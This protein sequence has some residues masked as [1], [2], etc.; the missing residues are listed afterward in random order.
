MI[1]ILLL[2][3]FK[4]VSTFMK[5]M[6]IV[7][8]TSLFLTR[9]EIMSSIQKLTSQLI[10]E[11]EYTLFCS[12]IMYYTNHLPTEFIGQLAEF[13]QL[14]NNYL[15]SED[16]PC[17][18]IRTKRN[19]CVECQMK[20]E[21]TTKFKSI[22]YYAS[23]KPEICLQVSYKCKNCKLFYFHSYYQSE[24]KRTFEEDC[25]ENE[26]IQFTDE[27]VFETTLLM[28]LNANIVKMNSTFDG[29]TASQNMTFRNENLGER[30]SLNLK[31][32]IE[33][34]FYFQ[35][36]KFHKTTESFSLPEFHAPTNILKLD[37]KINEIIPKLLQIFVSKWTGDFH[38]AN[39]KHPMCSKTLNVDGI[40]KVLI[41][42][43]NEIFLNN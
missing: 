1:N 2:K 22:V 41:N 28:I 16:L 26:F 8:K 9:K 19:K 37:E 18:Q 14:L 24:T 4:D 17:M 30:G 39:C 6:Y 21:E 34:Y 40:W 32:L 12:N 15:S 31:R 38:T 35:L 42:K 11:R 33:S 3:P 13:D 10:D 36:V 20:I 23:K 5:A 7:K 25:L 43:N 29:F 27:T